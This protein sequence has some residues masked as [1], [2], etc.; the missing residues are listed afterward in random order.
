MESKFVMHPTGDWKMTH[1]MMV[2]SG[3]QLS[4][5]AGGHSKK[6]TAGVAHGHKGF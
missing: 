2:T 6:V 3:E 1:T 5:G 4:I